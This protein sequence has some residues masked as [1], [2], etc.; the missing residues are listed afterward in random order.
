MGGNGVLFANQLIKHVSAAPQEEK[1][2][3]SASQL[4]DVGR[5]ADATPLQG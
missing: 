2:K 1:K 4:A 3:H 5:V